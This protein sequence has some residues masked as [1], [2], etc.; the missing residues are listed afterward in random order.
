MYR[1]EEVI[2]NGVSHIF[3]WLNG[4]LVNISLGDVLEPYH[5]DKPEKNLLEYQWKAASRR[6]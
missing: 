5:P 4:V 3:T 6:G 1:H 2:I